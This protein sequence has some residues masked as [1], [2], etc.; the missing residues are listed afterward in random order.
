MSII[1]YKKTGWSKNKDKEKFQLLVSF[2][3]E[4]ERDIFTEV[5]N[6]IQE[7]MDKGV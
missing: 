6:N 4:I 2:D 5:I 7:L 1:G 3:T